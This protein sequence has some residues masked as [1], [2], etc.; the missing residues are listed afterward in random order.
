MPAFDFNPDYYEAQFILSNTAIRVPFTVKTGLFLPQ[1][2][3]Y[4]QRQNV[5][6]LD[7]QNIVQLLVEDKSLYEHFHKITSEHL[8]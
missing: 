2:V 8:D 3:S 6:V 5:K 4:L 7:S 1:F